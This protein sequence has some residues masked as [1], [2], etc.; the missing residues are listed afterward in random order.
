[1]FDPYLD[2][3]FFLWLWL[4]FRRG[5]WAAVISNPFIYIFS[6]QTHEQWKELINNASN[7][8]GIDITNS[9]VEG[10]V[11]N[12]TPEVAK[13]LV[14]MAKPF[15]AA[16]PPL[17]SVIDKNHF[18]MLWRRRGGLEQTTC[19]ARVF[20]IA[21][22]KAYRR[23]PWLCSTIVGGFVMIIVMDWVLSCSVFEFVFDA[24]AAAPVKCFHDWWRCWRCCRLPVGPQ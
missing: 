11:Q 8:G 9:T 16:G 17:D 19:V 18:V 1:M 6:L 7:D 20:A 24:F 14:N 23:L 22:D 3:D 15:D 2:F 21:N 5:L 10:T 12:V 4:N 13:E